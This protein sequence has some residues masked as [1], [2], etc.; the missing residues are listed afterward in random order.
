MIPSWLYIAFISGLLSN[1]S[2]FFHR[3]LL[4]DDKD[5]A[6]YTWFLEATR[7]VIAL[8]LLPFNFYFIFS[9]K[10]VFLLFVLGTV[11]AISIYIYMKQHASTKLSISTIISRTRLFWTA[12][13]AFIFLGEHLSP[14]TY[15][16]ILILF[17]GLS[18]GTSPKKI[19]TDDGIKYSYVSAI[20]ISVTNNLSKAVTPTASQSV[21]VI[22]L[23]LE[24]V[25]GYPLLLK[26]A[27]QRIYN[28][29][30]TKLLNKLLAAFANVGSLFFLLLALKTG[31]VSVVNAI[32]QG[33]MI[34]AVLAGILF[35]N[36]KDDIFKK[37]I[38]SAIA[39][40]GISL[41]SF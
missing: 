26:N 2:N 8:I 3:Y 13:F 19:V 23:A 27:P 38:G 7:L 12:L 5:P 40:I 15:V 25:F 35:L 31:P 16:G 24:T 22:A 9:T 10:T 37:L 17:F 18:V 30:K 41:L 20:L 32:Y 36:E 11:E 29:F 1:T 6:L 34:F 4:K 21:I 33:T 28:F 39:L 14:W